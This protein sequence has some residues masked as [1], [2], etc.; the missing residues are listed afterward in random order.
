MSTRCSHDP[1]GVISRQPLF[2][3]LGVEERC[4]LA[5]RSPCR[6][7]RRGEIIFREGEPCRGL[8]LILEGEVRVYRSNASGKEQVLATYRSGESIG[9]VA[10]F[11]EGPYLAAARATRDGRILFLPLDEVQALYQ[12]HPEVSHAVV[13]ELAQRVRKLAA[14]LDRMTLHDVP[15]R[16]ASA[17]LD[18]ASEVGAAFRG[19]AFELRCTQEELAAELGTARESVARALRELRE[20]GTIEQRGR[21]IG[22]RDL[23]RLQDAAGALQGPSSRSRI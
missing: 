6:A 1:A 8:Y 12:T 20:S 19:G 16:V 2:A 23:K 18:Q 4:A 7:I 17:L 9:E 22:V 14:L 15:A 5:R 3:S 21:R 10:L 11:D 13:R